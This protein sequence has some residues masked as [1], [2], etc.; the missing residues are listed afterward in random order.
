MKYSTK[1][2]Q[3]NVKNLVWSSVGFEPS[4][5]VWSSGFFEGFFGRRTWVQKGMKFGFS[6]FGFGFDLYLAKQVR[7]SDNLQGFKRV[8]SSFLV[9]RPGFERVRSS[10]C[11]IRSSSKFDIFGFD[12]TLV[13][14]Y[15]I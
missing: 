8:R 6:K 11:Q 3:K 14:I 10:T 1:G 5:W 4:S 12:P 2:S 13:P 15:T 7:N 9:D